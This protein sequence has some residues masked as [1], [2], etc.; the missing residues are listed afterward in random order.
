MRFN[1]SNGTTNKW[2]YNYQYAGIIAK[3]IPNAKIIHCFRNPLDNILS[4]YRANF[5][6]GNQYS[7]SLEDCAKVL[8]N[9]ESKM[10]IYKNQFRSKIYDLD[11]ELLVKKPQ[12]IIKSLIEWLGW[13]WNDNF[14]SPH[15]NKRPVLT[16]SNVE[17]RSPI[18]SKSLGGWKNYKKMLKPAIKILSQE[19]F[20]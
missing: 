17:I 2:L 20:L 15:L 12:L 3:A 6:K 16:R 8:L 7:S 14:L 19:N 9:Q 1:I 4:I 10:Q 5:S 13:E 11:Y 18:H